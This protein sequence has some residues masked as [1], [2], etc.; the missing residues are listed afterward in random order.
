MGAFWNI[1]P[2]VTIIEGTLSSIE[3]ANKRDDMLSRPLQAYLHIMNDGFFLESV[4]ELMIGGP[5]A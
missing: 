2:F 4:P 5:S 3:D 1:R